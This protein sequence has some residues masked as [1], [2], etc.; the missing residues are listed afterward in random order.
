MLKRILKNNYILNIISK[1][2]NLVFAVGASAFITRFMGDSL[3]GEYA[4]ITSF[5]A[6]SSIFCNLGVYQA[7]PNQVKN[8]LENA[9][10]KFVDVFFL[11]MALCILLGAGILSVM[12]IVPQ[13]APQTLTALMIILVTIFSMMSSQ[14]IMICM[15]EHPLFRS[16][17]QIIT[18]FVNLIICAA[19][20]F[21]VKTPNIIIPVIALLS[22]EV[23]MIA[24]ILFKEKVLPKPW[25]ADLKL[26]AKLVGFGF[27]PMVTSLLLNVNYKMDVFM[28]KWLTT[29]ATVGV[30]SVGVYFADQIWLIPDSF[31]E[32]L[33]SRAVK[34]D[35]RKSFNLSI[36]LSIVITAFVCVLVAIFGKIGIYILYGTEFLNAYD[37]LLILLIGIPFMSIFKVISPL[38]I[39]EGKTGRYF[40]N[41]LCG[42]VI[43][44][45][46]NF[47]LIPNYGIY[48][49]AIAT[50]AS[51]MVCGIVALVM[52]KS[53]TDEKISQILIPSKS[54]I[55]A[56]TQLLKRKGK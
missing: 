40:I 34:V 56:I 50:I 41:L 37:S 27:L 46:L 10:Q 54:D 42:V 47:T 1:I 36:K 32:V 24:L 17:A 18:S 5:A 55:K 6:I 48:G 9:K 21:L 45:I 22:K 52:Y 23:L 15:V 2:C 31:K 49:A 20:F 26:F 7:Y 14:I 13:F 3:K 33:F 16:I 53:G 43:N 30:Y 12:Y 35:A 4:Y 11:Q 38:F 25:K 29:S 39:T 44:F 28:L 19:V 51:Q 8:G